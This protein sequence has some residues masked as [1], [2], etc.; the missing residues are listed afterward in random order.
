MTGRYLSEKLRYT[1]MEVGVRKLALDSNLVTPQGLAIM[2]EIEVC[3]LV[4]EEYDLVYSEDEK[5]GLVHKDKIS[6]FNKL[7]TVISR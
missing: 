3:N 2:S 7:I 1:G 4:A 5:I 6:E